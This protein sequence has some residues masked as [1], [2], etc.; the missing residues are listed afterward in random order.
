MNLDLLTSTTRIK[1]RFN[2]CDPLQM[3]WHG[4]Y[5]KYFEVSREEFC[6]LHG[7]S[8]LNMKERGWSTPVV[9]SLCEYKL[10]LKYGD[11]F[12][13]ETRFIPT[14]SAKITFQYKILM[15]DDLVCTGET[16]QV[17]L[18]E[19]GKLI[20]NNPPFFLDWKKNMGID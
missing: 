4:N 14:A 3:V 12:L 19:Q 8:Y 16:V 18:D 7:F 2:E 9:K 1:V 13:V 10:P 11:V 17:F 20:L 5:L 6:S 15:G